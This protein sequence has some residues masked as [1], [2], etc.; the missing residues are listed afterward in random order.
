MATL[1]M[2]IIGSPAAAFATTDEVVLRR[3][4]EAGE[5]AVAEYDDDL[6]G[7]TGNTGGDT[8]GDSNDATG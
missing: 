2:A 7:D 5:V 8:S 4:E 6:T 1:A 3:D